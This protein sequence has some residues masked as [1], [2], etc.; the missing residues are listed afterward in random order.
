MIF[1]FERTC[2]E[3]AGKLDRSEAPTTFLCQ[4]QNALAFWHRPQVVVELALKNLISVVSIFERTP[5][6]CRP[7]PAPG[8][9][10]VL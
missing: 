7:R 3:K 5:L 4:P 10:P 8:L 9:P 6:L 2:E 1:I